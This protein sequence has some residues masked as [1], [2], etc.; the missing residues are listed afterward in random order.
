[1]ISGLSLIPGTTFYIRWLDF[2]ASGADDGL[3]VD[4]FTVTPVGTPPNV[5][6]IS[7]SPS[8]L[9]FGEINVNDADTLS[10]RVIASNLTDSINV[11]SSDSVYTLSVDRITF[12]SSV[13]LPDSGGFVYVRFQ[14]VSNGV[15]NG[16]I[17][18]TNT[19]ITDSLTVTGKGFDQASNIIAISAARLKAAGEKVTVAGR[20]TAGF[21]L[22]NPAYLQD[23]TGGIPVFY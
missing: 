6:S 3:S 12:S 4:N 18:H 15:V 19:E 7:F 17:A 2:N 21:E 11:S 8:Q 10:Y 22:G 1:V 13:T 16:V 5:P 9:N 14:P 23:N 20:I